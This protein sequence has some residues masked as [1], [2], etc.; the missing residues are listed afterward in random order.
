MSN[1]NELTIEQLMEIASTDRKAVSNLTDDKSN[2]MEYIR[3]Q[4]ITDG[5]TLVPNFLVYYD[6]CRNWKPAGKKLSKIGFLRKFSVVYNSK[7]TKDTR[8]YLLNE[9]AFDISEEA[10]YE[11]KQFDKRYR[12]KIE[13]K[14]KQKKQRK[15]SS[16]TEEV[17]SEDET[18]LHRS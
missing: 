10:L 5:C 12:N 9:E 13:K 8:Y 17:Q 4:E 11:A 7:R 6:Y 2:I 14:T 3:E 1:A 18:G 15:I 16:T